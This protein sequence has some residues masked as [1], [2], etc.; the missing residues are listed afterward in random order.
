MHK[1]IKIMI[2][3][4]TA[5]YI[6]GCSFH[7]SKYGASFENI[8]TLKNYKGVQVAVKPFTS[9]KPGQSGISC[10]GAG[11]VETPN[12]ESF[13]SYIHSAFVSELKVAGVYEEQSEIILNGH[14]TEIDFNSNIGNGKWMFELTASSSNDNAVKIST[15]H[16][17]STNWVADKACQQVAQEF[18]PAVQLLIRDLITHP[19]FKELIA[20]VKTELVTKI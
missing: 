3:G 11:S 17:F 9:V 12:K 2:I 5:I 8:E 10:R 16:E 4:I 20:P 7:A 14:F 13:E 19:K 15:R 18:S 1:T 6:S